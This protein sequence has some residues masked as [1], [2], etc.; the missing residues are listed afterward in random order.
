MKQ[1]EIDAEV[2]RAAFARVGLAAFIVDSEGRVTAV[3]G[4]ASDLFARPIEEM[5]G[6]IVPDVPESILESLRRNEH[7]FDEFDA[8]VGAQI[9]SIAIDATPHVR[10]DA[11]LLLLRDVTERRRREAMND[12]Y[13]LLARYT[14]DIVLFIEPDGRI[15]EANDAALKA[16]GYSLD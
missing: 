11:H 9:L 14:N 6:K 13:Q 15:V 3:N 4:A 12:R 8:R 5:V 2:A 10:K 1:A 16:Y 7:V